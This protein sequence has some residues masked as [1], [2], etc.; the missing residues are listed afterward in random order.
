MK[1]KLSAIKELNV[2]MMWQHIQCS[3]TAERLS[4]TQSIRLD[5]KEIECVVATEVLFGCLCLRSEGN[6]KAFCFSSCGEH[7]EDRRCEK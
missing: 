2:L 6:M 1:H 4:Y 5:V 3:I 7:N